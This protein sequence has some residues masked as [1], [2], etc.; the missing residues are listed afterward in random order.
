MTNSYLGFLG[1]D[2]GHIPLRLRV[3]DAQGDPLPGRQYVN[4]DTSMCG[5]VPAW[6]LMELLDTPILREQRLQDERDERP[7]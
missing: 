1:V 5:V 7:T 3:L 6:R 4:S 2:W